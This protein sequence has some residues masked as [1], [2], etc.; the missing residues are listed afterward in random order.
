M[1][2]LWINS[3]EQQILFA[4]LSFTF[5]PYYRQY[6]KKAG[7][8]VGYYTRTEES[9]VLIFLVNYLLNVC[10]VSY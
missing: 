4:L 9:L 7:V 8:L 2:S 10:G 6:Q 1:R 5:G 3:R